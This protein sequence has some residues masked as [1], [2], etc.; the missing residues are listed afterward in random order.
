MK[1][2]HTNFSKAILFSLIILFLG[3]MSVSITHAETYN[4]RLSAPIQNTE[5]RITADG[6]NQLYP[7]IY[8]DRIAWQDERNGISIYMYDI[9]TSTETQVS[10]NS[11]GFN[12]NPAIDGNRVVWTS[13]YLY[14]YDFSTSKAS[15]LATAYSA[16][17]NPSIYGDR[18]VWQDTRNGNFDVYLYNLTTP[19]ETRITNHGADQHTPSVYGNRI[20][21]MDHRNGNW[22]IYM[23]DLST[24]T[25]TQITNNSADQNVPS[26]YGNK[27]VWMDNRNGN[28]DIYMYDLS[29]STENQITTNNTD[30]QVPS[31]YGDKIV[32]MDRRNGNWDIYMYDLSAST[33]T[34]ITNNSTDQIYPQI[35]GN[36]IV[37]QD[38]RNGN[39]DI[40][41]F[42][43][44]GSG[45]TPAPILPVANFTTN[46]TSGYAPLTISFTDTS[47]NA[48]YWYWDFGDGSNSTLENPIHTYTA[49]N[50]TVNLTVSNTNGTDPKVCQITVLEQPAPILPVANFT[51]N[52]TSGYA[53]LAVSFTD[54]SANA[55]YWNW[56]FGDGNT[57]NEQSPIYTYSNAGIYTVNLTVSNANGTNS[58]LS[59]ISLLSSTPVYYSGNDHYYDVISVPGG[60]TWGDA[61]AA[62]ESLSY[63]GISGH[64][65][66]ITS[67]GENDFIVNNL[68]VHDYWLGGI[69]PPNNSE[70]NSGWQ[71]VTGE[72]WVYTNWDYGEPSNSYWG[73]YSINL[74]NG[75]PEDAL[76]FHGNSRWNDVPKECPIT[77]Y[78]V[79][80]EVV[81][82]NPQSV[83]DIQSSS[84][85]TWINWTW[86]NPFDPNFNH[87]EIYLNG[88]FQTNTSA[89]HFNAT[90][91]QP[92][93]NYTI[94]VRTVDN[95]G[96]VNQTLVNDTAK[97]LSLP[98]TIS[99]V[100]DSVTLFPTSTTTGSTINVTVNVTDNVVVSSV[101][102]NDIALI[103]QG[104]SIWNGSI[105]ALEGIQSVNVSAV[106]GA[107][108]TAWDN[109][110]SYT[111]TTPD[112]LPPS[113]VANLQSTNGT[114]WINWTWTNPS[115]PDF[116]HTE[117][118]LNG[119]FQTSISAEHFN[120][121][122]L[123]PN[124]GYTISTRT[125]D[126][127]GNINQTWVNATAKTGAEIITEDFNVS[128]STD[129]S[130]Y[131]RG[132]TVN[133]T[134][135]AQYINGSPVANAPA[136]LNIK[137]KGYSQTY[138]LVTDSRGNISYNFKPGKTGAGNFTAK[139]TV[140]S[141]GHLMSAETPFNM[142]GLY[143]TPSG[144]IDYEMSKNS[145]ENITFTLL[146]YGETDLHGVNVSLEGDTIAGLETQVLQMPPETLAAGAQGSFIVE[147]SSANVDVS[148]ANYTVRVTTDEGSYEE[149]KLFVHL[150]DAKPAA[151]VSPTSIEVGLNPNNNLVKTVTISN[152]GYESMNDV[153]ISKPSLNWISVS[154]T[155]LGNISPG[156]N[157][158]FN[159]FLNSDND[160]AVGVY[161]EAI[162]ISSS[163]HQ[164][165]NIYLRISVTSSEKGDL[166]F[167]VVNDLGENVSGASI[168]IQNPAV[169]TEIFTGTADEN[170]NY[171][172]E[173]ISAGMYNYFVTASGH[174]VSGSSLVSPGI[175]A[176]VEP[177][178]PKDIL[179]VKLNVTLVKIDD[180]YVI[181]PN[182]TF[183][184]DVPPPLLIPD[185]VAI[186]HG[187]DPLNPVY[188]KDGNITI[189]NSGLIS[190]FNV[191]MD[192]SALQGVNITFPTG[193]TFFVDE[194]KAK[195]SITV[196]YHL[197]VN[198]VAC[199]VNEYRNSIRINGDYLYFEPRSDLTHTGYVSSEIPVFAY[200]YNC[201]VDTP[202]VIEDYFIFIYSAPAASYS[203]IPI[204]VEPIPQV[205]T[206]HERVKFNIPQKATFER[207]AFDAGLEL[208]NKITDQ[209]I[210]NV[211]VNLTIKD[212]DGNDASSLFFVSQPS[213][214]NINSIDGSGVISPSSVANANWLLVPK[215][216]AGGT[217]LSGKDYT[218]QAFINYSVDG[219]SFSTNSTEESITVIP[220][221]LLNLTYTI[222]ENVTA[223]KPFNINLTVANVGYG[224]AR[225]LKL[226]SGQP[227]IYENKAGLLITFELIGSGLVNGPESN[228]MLINFGD[229]PP[230]ESKEAYWVM[231]TSLGGNF[232][233]FKGSFSHSNALGGA[234]TSLINSI[235]YIIVKESDTNPPSS[236][237]NLQS[238][239]STTG[240]N[241]SWTNPSDIDFS[242][243]EIYLNGIF[244]S[245]T[246][247]EYFNATNLQPETSYTISTR[248]VDMNGNVNE[249]WVN[250]TAITGKE[251]PPS[252]P[253]ANFSSNMTSGPAPLY[254]KFIDLSEDAT[255]WNWDFGDGFNSTDQSPMHTYNKNG[256]YNVSLTVT[257][258]GGSNSTVKIGYISVSSPVPVKPV[259]AFSASPTLGIIPL[260]VQFTDQST[261]VP[262][263]YTW[264]FGDGNTSTEQ[265]PSHVYSKVGKF[266][267]KLTV[268]NALGSNSITKT[269]YIDVKVVPV[270]EFS[271]NKTIGKMPMSV[272][273]T[274]KSIGDPTSW[275]WDFGDGNTSTD[276]TPVHVYGAVGKYNVTLTAT[277]AVGNNTI[278]KTKYI[279]VEGVPVAGFSADA[280]VGIMP[281]NV[282]FTDLS[283]GVPANWTW[284]FGDGNTSTEQNPSH[285]YSKVGTFTV[286]LTSKNAVGSNTTT[287][288]KYIDVEV[289][290]IAEFSANKTL[291]K[292]PLSVK[293]TDKS[294][295]DPTSWNWDFGDGSISTEEKPVHTYSEVGR[296]NVTLTATNTVGN[297]T[298]TKSSYIDV[299]A[300][301]AANFSADSTIG[302]VPFNVSFT[303][304]ST[305]V[306]TSWSW[307]FGDGN[308]ST[309]QN[310]SH[311][312]SKGGQ[313]TVKLTAKNAVG[314]N[315]TTMTKYITVESIPVASFSATPTSGT[316]PLNVTFT[317]KS[318][319]YPES[320][321]WEFGDGSSSTEQNPLHTYSEAGKYTVNLTVTNLAGSG[322]KSMSS[323]IK[324]S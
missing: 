242:H 182:F 234:D 229:L 256:T 131:D 302:A 174:S 313:Y 213:L 202:G 303:E 274:D 228:S 122:N 230:G 269:K 112:N 231:K 64:L 115:D 214:S 59:T 210:E 307:T 239:N 253:V 250:E 183:E 160:T 208:T 171:T 276:E 262:T 136:S 310:P 167:H 3:L 233:E 75:S 38:N 181:T 292:V 226:D 52:V 243:T 199:G 62:A 143:L 60:I 26:I 128:I 146:N 33:E 91:L 111:A 322:T 7:H 125:V 71:W 153:T 161:Q 259:A 44:S 251:I 275:L 232:T 104:G 31:I 225:N 280:T 197:K 17:Y 297:N 266:T 314:S 317:D 286:K 263:N 283:T 32:W 294:T 119:T 178:L 201:P 195:S 249:T 145:S 319:G 108:N 154:L 193:H 291:G 141:N 14:S 96:N 28:W 132:E 110:T 172:F 139:L 130:I 48:T 94:G 15:Q 105:T 121:T 101:N 5:T 4:F 282:S 272:K 212:K 81:N 157:K 198:N 37:W 21:W 66:T 124:T 209:N 150:V 318:T 72:P 320:W 227:V 293:F 255:G 196:P 36:R 56:D 206:V 191:T 87:T 159:I 245:N 40:Y 22:D 312:Y 70:P 8:D 252:I 179:G 85:S 164:P 168:K 185:P 27:I 305:G 76:H 142:Y 47:T 184:T 129:K 200:E 116:N 147:V 158:S 192:S 19:K 238:T 285:V 190:V 120:A 203:P 1:Y 299:E 241:W 194:I 316:H 235:R 63:F 188:E 117:I 55:T 165:V 284:S 152:V 2:L 218:V 78:I 287:K 248:T 77:G 126:N 138:S 220:Q 134:G 309:E 88:T 133:I 68:G 260:N 84:G 279:D 207:D 173:N 113:S 170:G 222:P 211:S 189:S 151:I 224:T 69:Q 223:D 95:S 67:Q 12:P 187:V 102:A 90:G 97:T 237:T 43:L 308:T 140:N 54:Q 53:P 79:E 162:T 246:S 123:Q 186:I 50:Y 306:P 24:S 98:D 205:E 39:W 261:G 169:L 46:V 278:T 73:G 99:P 236:I 137:L 177:V 58:K 163:N 300:V 25:E 155:N 23:Y 118:Y 217:D 149:A 311:I 103:N 16:K 258:P 61:K 324:V 166:K 34:Q 271:A 18:V 93:T 100:I 216:N 270:A 240:I 74:P 281:L 107:G 176:L 257:G 20:V 273:F 51:A 288:T 57:S 41:M 35:Y 86:K 30:Q 219:K 221:P 9:S 114:T 277:N 11:L 45:P 290:P 29:T 264:T 148:E 65:A 304:Q 156:M 49:G 175:Q 244:R 6:S 106:D 267:V 204:N 89:E 13:G 215:N 127:N 10:A 268:K 109:T 265:N 289:V 295:G 301:P 135:K 321:Y 82:P 315:S 254:V 42:T 83:S 80:F 144:T 92:E 323:Y 180:E 298:I 296:Y 247:A